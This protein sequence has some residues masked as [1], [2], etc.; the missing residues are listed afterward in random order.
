MSLI[1]SIILG[2][3]QGIS[4]FL[5]ISSDGHLVI[6][7]QFF[8]LNSEKETTMLFDVFLHF[9]TL[10]AVVVAF[11]KTIVLLFKDFIEMVIRIFKGKY[12]YKKSTPHQKMI[13]LI[14]ISLIPLL[15]VLP[16]KGEIENLYHTAKA[17]G[18]G[19]LITAVFLF[20]ADR[21]KKGKNDANS[22]KPVHSLLVGLFQATATLPGVSRSGSTISTGLMLGF[23]REFAVE[24]SFI[25]AIPAILGANIISFK[26]AIDSNINISNPTPFI[27]GAIISAV[28]G[29]FAI[30]LITFLVK[31]DM[32]KIFAFYCTA[33]GII[34]IVAA[35][36]LNK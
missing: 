3:V 20:L 8:G 13:V 36:I 19:F 15:I 14:L 34:T 21:A 1:E 30:K 18:V 4:E 6:F 28:V 23:S 35:F 32:F 16:L 22:V 11:W 27:I 24:F 2:I 10:I 25:M 17:A 26:D 9:G 12:S 7:Q 31:K 33:L 5:P 29:F